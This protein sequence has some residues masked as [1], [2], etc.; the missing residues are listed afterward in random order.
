MKRLAYL[1]LSAAL[2]TTTTASADDP[3]NLGIA[4]DE[5]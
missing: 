5:Q 1:L 4:V 3:G 2:L